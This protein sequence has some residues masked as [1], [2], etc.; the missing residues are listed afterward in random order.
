LKFFQDCRTY[1]TIA[2]LARP[3]WLHAFPLPQLEDPII[4][5]WGALWV[6]CVC[7]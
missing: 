6:H 2:A 3:R 4:P 5:F 1:G 7:G